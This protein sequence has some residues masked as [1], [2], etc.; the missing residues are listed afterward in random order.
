VSPVARAAV[1]QQLRQLPMQ[2][3]SQTSNYLRATFELDPQPSD[4]LLGTTILPG[5]V[6]GHDGA[7]LYY[8]MDLEG[9]KFVAQVI[10]VR[11]VRDDD[12]QDGDEVKIGDR[13]LHVLPLDGQTI[14]TYVDSRHHN[15]FIYSAPDISPNELVWLAGSGLL[16][17]R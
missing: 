2:R 13:T 12:M 15:G 4:N 9:R 10:A 8:Q 16:P 1:R 7:K 14:V 11:D 6:M 5:G 3:D 17:P